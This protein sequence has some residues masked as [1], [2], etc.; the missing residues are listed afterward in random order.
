[1]KYSILV[2]T[3]EKLE[4]TPSKLGKRDILSELFLKTPSKKLPRVVLLIMG[5]VFPSY[6]EHE[7]GIANQMMMKTVSKA[8]GFSSGDIEKK[9]K[10]R[11]DLGL[12]TEECVKSRK[13]KILFKKELTVDN[14][15]ENLHKL[16][17]ITGVGSQERKLNLITELLTSAKPKEARYI[18][19]TILQELRIGV[20]EGIMRDAIGKAFL[21]KEGMTKEEKNE[22]IEAVEYA[23]N[24]MS[25]FGE[26]VKIAREKGIGGLEKVKIRLGKPIRVM[27]GE[28]TE[29][30]EDVIKDF[31]KIAVEYKYDGMR[32][33]I[34][35]K[36]D[37]IWVYTRRLENMTNQFPDLVD[38]CKKGLKSRECI[39]EGE[40]FGINPRTKLPLP[41]QLLSQRIRRKYDI[42][43]MVKEIPVKL[44]LFD[45]VYLD[46]KPLFNKKFIDRRK[47]LETKVKI[48]PNKLELAKQLVTDDIKKIQKFYKK[49]LAARQEGLFLKVLDSKYVFGRRVGGWYKIKPIMETLDLVIVGGTWG[50]GSRVNWL[51][52]YVLA[53]RDPDTGKFLPCG[54]MGTG[55]TEEQF[56]LMTD[57]LKG[58]IL[59][60]KGRR[61]VLKPK[62]VV[63][64][65][66]QEIQKSPKYESGYALRFPRLIG[67]REDKSS[68][69]ADTVKRVSDLFKTQGKAQ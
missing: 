50:I 67:I 7:L 64:V 44:H 30:I 26:I 47:I 42:E 20:A 46:G 54:M 48:I 60:E 14:V 56:K 41:F 63:E 45:I 15:F 1:M 8:T 52:S 2:D 49:A 69:E 4:E 19:R 5:R 39:V 57:I 10:E 68:N 58:L 32:T 31:G 23:W 65:A 3:Y 43:R 59:K 21:I 27:L 16:A 66:Y 35:K 40:V 18:V 28:K 33:Q 62:I 29:S 24:I 13:Q 51:S 53:C 9:F 6:S 12:A 11:G 61:V 38:V 22:M 25:D 37:R 36:D 17:F 34:H 55:L